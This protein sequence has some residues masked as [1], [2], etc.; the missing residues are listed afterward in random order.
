M[1]QPELFDTPPAARVKAGQHRAARGEETPL[2]MKRRA[3]KIN[4]VLGLGYPDAECELDFSNPLELTVATIL[5]AQCTDARV[6]QVT[7]ALFRRY[8]TAMEYAT[9]DQ[10][11]LESYIH[12]TGFYRAK[13]RNLIGMGQKLVADF[14]GEVPKKLEAL[15]TL[16]GVGRKT[17]HVV[18]SSVF[19]LP[20]ITV[21]THFGRLVRRWGLTTQEDPVKVEREIAEIIERREWSNFSD[22]TVFHGRRVCHARQP[23]CGACLIAHLCPSYGTG[24][25]SPDAAELVKGEEAPR[26]LELAGLGPAELREEVSA[27]A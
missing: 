6:N 17:A 22:R 25:T 20:G 19:G 8:P 18:R 13:A 1:Q 24:P 27:H 4:R 23:A 26:L 11:E 21:D 10:A 16:P 14:G 12:S 3:R 9:A 2:G 7:P 5:S 15:V